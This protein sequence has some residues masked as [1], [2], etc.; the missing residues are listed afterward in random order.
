MLN[1]AD[2]KPVRQVILPRPYPTFLP[3]FFDTPGTSVLNNST[4]E[5]LQISLGPGL[6][7]RDGPYRFEIE[8]VRL[9]WD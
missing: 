6:D 8:S 4:I 2:L 5:T 9:D 7:N 3:Y 1:L